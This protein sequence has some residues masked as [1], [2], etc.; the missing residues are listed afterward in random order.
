MSFYYEEHGQFV[1]H[2]TSLGYKESCIALGLDS[3]GIQS[4]WEAGKMQRESNESLDGMC[5]KGV[6]EALGPCS[7]SFTNEFRVPARCQGLGLALGLE[8]VPALQLMSKSGN[9]VI[10]TPKCSKS[11][12]QWELG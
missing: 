9:M 8:L 3:S 4:Q 7:H 6:T 5:V 11:K 12:V 10:E 2:V 1:D